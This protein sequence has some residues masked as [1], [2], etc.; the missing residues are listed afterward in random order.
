[1]PVRLIVLCALFA[2]PV[3]A[4]DDLLTVAE[5]SDWQA[6]A[7]YDEVIDLLDRIQQR[8]TVMRRLEMGR[9][10][11]D[12][13][14][15]LVVLADPPIESAAQAQASGKPIV[16]AFGNIH[17]GEVC[18]KEALLMLT[19]ELAT[20]NDPG[21]LKR[22]VIVFAPIYNADGNERMSPDNRPGQVGPAQGMGQRANAQGLD[23]NRDY[24]KLESP[25]A[26]A[27]VDV[28]TMWDPHVTVDTHTTN[29]SRHRY[30]LTYAAPHNPS[31]H[32]EPIRLVRNL[33]LPEITGRLRWRCGFETFFY[34][35]FNDDRTEWR[36]YPA[37]AR[38]GGPY[39]GLRGQMSI[40]SEAYAY[41]SYRDRV[42]AT[43]EFMFEVI[44]ST[45]RHRD[46]IM[47][48]AERTRR[49]ITDAGL[50]PGPDDL[51]G[52]R[53]RP[54]AF[55]EPV[56]IKTFAD[57]ESDEPRDLRVRHLGRFEPTLSVPRPHA[58]ILGPG[59]EH[60]ARKLF[61]H[62]IE[63]Q[64]FAGD[65]TVE[66]YT[67]TAIERAEKP[68]QGHRL[69]R[70]EANATRHR[71]TFDDGVIVSTAQPLG[72]LAVYLL[73]PQSDDGLATWNFFDDHLT[74]GGE[75]PVYRVSSPDDLRRRD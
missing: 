11:E 36:A 65:A 37:L 31:G 24:V 12:R 74:V 41:A 2:A 54:A 53:H 40:L 71:R 33:I 27:L 10:V 52:L 48:V 59:L 60:V 70:L 26:R 75:F 58:Y 5:R 57:D 3:P 28:L 25:E 35:N 62:G 46:L 19:R 22:L 21:F 9:T 51:V 8:S 61:Q 72:T 15:P 69:V 6:T 32:P 49:E 38:F 68:F 20:G 13:S 44:H 17:A 47:D 64:P 7:S 45:H 14:I 73:E 30:R 67:I 23:L 55:D 43:Y 29:G 1:M 18:G 50:R 56:V 34:G 63:V 16:F 42:M 39:R 4:A 66:A